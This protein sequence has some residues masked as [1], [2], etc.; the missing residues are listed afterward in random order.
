MFGKLF[1]R[2]GGDAPQA[3]AQP[4]DLHHE[5]AA[6]LNRWLMQCANSERG[7]HVETMTAMLGALAGM[8]CQIAARHALLDGPRH[9]GT[10]WAVAT[11]ADGATYYFGDAIN[12]FLLEDRLSLWSLAAGAVAA[13]GE[14]V[15]DVIPLV[16]HVSATVG[17]EAFGE[18]H[19]PEG[20][21]ADGAPADYVRHLFPDVQEN[22]ARLGLEPTE[23][24]TAF[25]LAAQDFLRMARD[26][27]APPAALLVLMECAIVMAKVD[28]APL[29]LSAPTP[30]Q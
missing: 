27:V 13:L 11:G 22:F 18:I 2:K 19:Y 10:P 8:A 21:S 20:T 4:S 26:V 9:W 12:H 28:P 23:W 24:P 5:A 16:Q 6:Q 3:A 25:G 1:G 29:G 30:G 7:V 15:P 14:E 17:S